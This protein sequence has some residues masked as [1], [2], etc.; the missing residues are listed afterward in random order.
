MKD[1][2]KIEYELNEK[3]H[4]TKERVIWIAYTLYYAYTI[5]LSKYLLEVKKNYINNKIGYL[6]FFFDIIIFV[7]STV[8]L[9]MQCKRKYVSV[10]KTEKIRNIIAD[11]DIEIIW[12]WFCKDQGK[13][14]EELLLKNNRRWFKTNRIEIVLY[15]IMFTLFIGKE[16]IIFE[17]F[18]IFKEP[19]YTIILITII[20]VVYYSACLIYHKYC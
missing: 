18:A 3:Y 1:I 13:V 17:T 9:Y 11:D 2:I 6:I 16:V 12:D 8:F 5:G 19:Y 20:S 15:L 4:D 14:E 7:L 10:L